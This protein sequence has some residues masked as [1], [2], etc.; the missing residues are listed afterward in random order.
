MGTCHLT[1]WYPH[2]TVGFPSGMDRPIMDPI[3]VQSSAWPGALTGASGGAYA[4]RPTVYYVYN[5]QATVGSMLYFAQRDHRVSS[6]QR[7][8][9]CQRQRQCRRTVT[10]HVVPTLTEE[11]YRILRTQHTYAYMYMEMDEC[12][13]DT[14]RSL[15]GVACARG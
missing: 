3:I 10:M 13:I 7:L 8:T 5:V 6:L 14:S 11:L 9:M 15:S 12:L 1:I 2:P 4:K